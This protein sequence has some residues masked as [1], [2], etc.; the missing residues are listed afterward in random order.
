MNK[1]EWLTS[2]VFYHIY[3]L[4]CLGAPD[5]NDFSMPSGNRLAQLSAWVSYL[6]DLGVNAIY[7]G[8]IFESSRHGY[9]TADFFTVDRRLGSNE[10]LVSLTASLESNGIKVVLDAVFHHTGRDFWAF[11]DVRENGPESRFRSWFY[12][13]FNKRSPYGD[14]FAYEGWNNNFD[15]V[16]LNV[17]HPEVK[18]HLFE[19][20]TFWMDNFW[21]SGLRLDAADALDRAFQ[22]E[23]VSLCR[24]RRPDF[25]VMG[26]VIY[27]DYRGWTQAGGLD[28]AT[29]YELFKGLWSSHNDVNYFEIA[30]SLNREFGELGIYRDLLLYNF[31]D[32]HTA[33]HGTRNPFHLLWQ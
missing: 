21:I 25:W 8:P 1:L 3:P 14:S 24:S 29:N 6:R 33:F 2:A 28:S 5:A 15:L 27:G 17:H 19:A 13:D 31:A 9:D 12:L 18:R 30:Y 20:V 10:D 4:G 7:L 22:R 26:E 32:N 23:L 11:R 16:K